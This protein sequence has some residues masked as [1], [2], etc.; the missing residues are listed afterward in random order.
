[1][2]V[3][4]KAQRI[5]QDYCIITAGS[6]PGKGYMENKSVKLSLLALMILV[7]HVFAAWTQNKFIIGC[8]W[9]PPV[10]GNQVSDKTEFQKLKDCGF[11]LM[12]GDGP[13][14]DHTFN[15]ATG[16]PYRLTIASQLG[17]QL[18]VSDGRYYGI[19]TPYNQVNIN[20]AIADYGGL[21]AAQRAA[22]YGYL[23]GDE[24]IPTM[25]T[26]NTYNNMGKISTISQLD[27]NR[28]AYMNLYSMSYFPFSATCATRYASW[29]YKR[30]YV[31]VYAGN[32]NTKIISFDFYPYIWDGGRFAMKNRFYQNNQIVATAAAPRMLP[33]WGY[34][35]VTES[36]WQQTG[37]AVANTSDERFPN[38]GYCETGAFS[39]CSPVRAYDG[40]VDF[41]VGMAGSNGVPALQVLAYAP[42]L[43][44][45]K[46]VVWYTYAPP[47]TVGCGP[48]NVTRTLSHFNS[49]MNDNVL[50]TRV[51]AIN[52]ILLNMGP[53]IMDANWIATFHG[54]SNNNEVGAF[55]ATTSESN[56][57]VLSE[58]T[59]LIATSSTIPA[60]CAV[61]VFRGIKSKYYYV[62]VLNKSRTSSN[63]VTLRFKNTIRNTWT[64]KK[65]SN[66][67][68]AA[69]NTGNT[70]NWA[71]TLSNIAPG[72]I[73]MVRVES[74]DIRRYLKAVIPD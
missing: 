37:V 68:N 62:I 52:T 7:P 6:S 8:W 33:F 47:G 43:Y 60:A 46:G 4:K 50:Y 32:T 72:D 5:H 10:T 73:Q 20:S 55:G 19:R 34:P 51:K 15:G 12:L 29:D 45:A 22:I 44:G 42:I 28:P 59:P 21:S 39:A 54:N 49:P 23:V 66:G 58:T 69:A 1:M 74:S 70:A 9:D 14:F 25:M 64:H 11:N 57:P 41:R 3:A 17:L 38:P 24:P 26:D 61:G 16:I 53:A 48:A 31:D 63:T 13:G 40:A 30:E 67:W 18:M 36:V 35:M 2:G 65:T 27:P 56:L 71:T